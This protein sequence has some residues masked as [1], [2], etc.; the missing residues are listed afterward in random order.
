VRSARRAAGQVAALARVSRAAARC[1]G[2]STLRAARIAR[3]VRR[4]QAFEYDEA[5]RVGLLDPAMPDAE[6]ALHVSRHENQEAQAPLSSGG[7]V[8]PITGDKLIFHRYCD[9]LGIPVPRLLGVLDRRGSS[10][11]A[12]GRLFLD[13]AGFERMVADDLPDEFVVKPSEGVEGEGV[14][15]L[16]RRDGLLVER[17]GAAMGAGE[18]W[19]ELRADP[20]YDVWIV[21]ERL[22]NHPEVA[23]LGG[24]ESLHTARL[25]TLVGRDGEPRPL[26]GFFKL[27]IA[28][29]ASDN[30]LGGRSGNAMAEIAVEDGRLG[31]VLTSRPGVP[32]FSA[33]ADS[34]ATGARA[35]GTTLPDWHAALALALEAAPHFLPARTLG[36]DIAL[37]P[38]GPVLLETNTRWASPPLPSMRAVNDRLREAALPGGRR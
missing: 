5:L 14:R 11:S 19:D 2:C 34:P 7:E 37:T 12:S 28:G 29:R 1:Y 26:F 22:R 10:W 31:P 35:A 3:R 20:A 8:P 13:R 9:A 24:D 23:R 33:G 38:G 36:W 21:Q 32:G 27:S 16:A 17:S 4:R 6:R 18:L 15:S 30:F 25:V